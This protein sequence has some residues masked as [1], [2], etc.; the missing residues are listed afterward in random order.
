[1]KRSVCCRRSFSS[2]S[3]NSGRAD[4]G[5][6]R[7]IFAISGLLSDKHDLR[8][9]TAFAENS[10]GSGLPQIARFASGGSGAKRRKRRAG[11]DQRLSCGVIGLAFGWCAFT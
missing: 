4:E 10:L 1:M 6:S 7:A 2:V 8:T 5:Q 11:G 3:R 9:G